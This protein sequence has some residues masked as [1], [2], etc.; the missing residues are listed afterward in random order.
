ML[1]A[2]P[3]LSPKPAAERLGDV[4]RGGFDGTRSGEEVFYLLIGALCLVP[5]FLLMDLMFRRYGQ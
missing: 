5:A 4:P 1:V 2:C 3:P